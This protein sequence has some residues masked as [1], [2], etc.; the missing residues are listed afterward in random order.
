MIIIHYRTYY[1]DKIMFRLFTYVMLFL[2]MS[3]SFAKM[4]SWRSYTISPEITNE[5]TNSTWFNGCPVAI[6]D[7]RLLTI[8]YYGFDNQIHQGILIVNKHIVHTTLYIFHQLFE[9]HFPIQEMVLIDHYNKEQRKV[10]NEINTIAFNC[11]RM[12]GNTHLFS[13]HS[14][15]LAIDINPLLNPY[16]SNHLVI[17]HQG[18]KFIN[19]HLKVP[20]MINR[21]DYIYHLFTQQGWQWGGNWRTIKDYMH[22]EIKTAMR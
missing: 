22:F 12:T 13:I 5:I 6:K 21:G 15:G 17:P 9:R 7:L 10:L 2:S 20:G 3:Y 11:R 18:I 14:Y 16:I 1:S 8:P 4:L 19:R